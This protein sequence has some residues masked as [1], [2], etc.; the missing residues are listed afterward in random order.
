MPPDVTAIRSDYA[1]GANLHVWQKINAWVCFADNRIASFCN[2]TRA[3]RL[4]W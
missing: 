2:K 1:D 4:P 3:G